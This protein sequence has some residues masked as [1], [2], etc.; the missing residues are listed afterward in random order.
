MRTTTLAQGTTTHRKEEVGAWRSRKLM[1]ETRDHSL[2]AEANHKVDLNNNNSSSKDM[3][4]RTRVDKDIL[5]RIIIMCLKA[6]IAIS[7][8]KSQ[9]TKMLMKLD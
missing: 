8:L 1:K 2:E 5:M 9:E 4:S 6:A 3:A 7:L